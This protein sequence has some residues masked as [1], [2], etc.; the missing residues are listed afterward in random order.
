MHTVNTILYI[1]GLQRISVYLTGR[2]YLKNYTLERVDCT[3][4]LVGDSST[5]RFKKVSRFIPPVS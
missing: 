1:E 5:A 3:G 4:Y 2:V